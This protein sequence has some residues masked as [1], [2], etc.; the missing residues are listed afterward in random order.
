MLF[1]SHAHLDFTT[2][3]SGGAIVDDLEKML[4]RAKRVDVSK[5]VTIGTSVECSKKCIE[6]AEKYS[7]DDLEIFATCGIHPED[8]KSDIEK[9]GDRLMDELRKVAQSSKKVVGI[10]ECGLD[11]YLEK[12]ERQK[13]TSGDEKEFQRKLFEEQIRLAIDLDLPLVVHC[14]NGWDEIFEVI[15]KHKISKLSGVFHSWTGNVDAMTKALDLEFYISFSGIVTFKNAPAIQEVARKAPID[16][17]LVETDSP[18]LTPD[19]FR[20]QKNEPSNVKITAAFLTDLKGLPFGDFCDQ[21][22]KNA[23]KLFNL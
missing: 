23:E 20:G 17:I 15:S 19:P 1:D 3:P 5:I 6:I 13:V 12:S 10:G 8:G 22:S 18:F 2:S 16:K 4:E 21:T 9:Y 14:R 7:E 11:Y